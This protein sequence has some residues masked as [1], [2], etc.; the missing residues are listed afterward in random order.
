MNAPV[1]RICPDCHE[2]LRSL[3]PLSGDPTYQCTIHGVFVVTR[4]SEAIGFWDAPEEDQQRALRHARRTA[5]K[6]KPPT[7]VF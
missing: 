7:V 1:S 4:T 6:G 3:P 5:L 2:L